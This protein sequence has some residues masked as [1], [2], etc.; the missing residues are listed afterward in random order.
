MVAKR[1]H[2]ICALFLAL[3][4][5]DSSVVQRNIVSASVHQS[6]IQPLPLLPVDEGRKMA[7]QGGFSQVLSASATGGTLDDSAHSQLGL[8]RSAMG[9]GG[10]VLYHSHRFWGA[11]ELTNG[12]GFVLGGTSIPREDWTI[13]LY[14]GFGMTT[15]Q[16]DVTYR[17]YKTTTV[18]TFVTHLDTVRSMRRV[19]DTV[20][21]LSA[22][23]G[24]AAQYQWGR[25]QPFGALRVIV[26]PRID[27]KTSLME[28]SPVAT[29]AI[30]L[31]EIR[32][33]AGTRIALFPRCHV[34]G[35]LGA[36]ASL[37]SKIDGVVW[38]GFAGLQWDIPEDP[39]Q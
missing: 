35:G 27:G 24:A 1:I 30:Q 7:I 3:G 33:D 6:P 19:R 28:G 15:Y 14:G 11:F 20:L 25:L 37:D 13:L 29:N 8:T 39:A 21:G 31:G 18:G 23:A 4:A 36:N 2:P 10:T 9:M 22:S 5:C 34:I 32:L 26:G 38:R 16:E 12:S 17:E